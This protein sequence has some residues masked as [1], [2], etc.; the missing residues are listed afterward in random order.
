M[1]KAV[2][3]TT[4]INSFR[5]T[6]FVFKE[7]KGSSLQDLIVDLSIITRDPA[8]QGDIFVVSFPSHQVLFRNTE[9]PFTQLGRIEA[10]IGYEVENLIMSPLEEMVVDFA[11]LDQTPT[12]SSVLVASVKR[13]L[14]RDYVS[15]L[16]QGG[17]VPDTIDVDSL[18][19]ARLVEE[20][21]GKRSIGLLDIGVV[22]GS[23]SIFQDG[24]L[25]FTRSIPIEAPGGSAAE[26]IRPVLDDVI[27]SVKA[28]QNTGDELLEEM[29]LTGGGSR[30][31]GLRSYVEQALGLR[32][33]DL[34]FTT[35]IPSDFPLPEEANVLGAVAMGL[36]LRGLRREKGRVDLVSKMPAHSEV[37]PP[38]IKKKVLKVAG[39]LLL[40][41]VLIGANFFLGIVAKERRY[42]ALKAEVRR[43]FKE[44]F[45]EVRGITNEV[46]QAREMVRRMGEGG[47][48]IRSSV[49]HSN[50]EILREIAQRLPE[51]SKI[52]SL[53]M[54]DVRINLRG[55]ATS[56][57]LVDEVEKVL[58]GS[59]LVEDV[60]VGNVELARRGGQG[61]LFKMVLSRKEK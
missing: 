1:I 11:L 4:S 35:R 44:A 56:F 53:D 24:K 32:V 55:T 46:Q 6:G 18:A 21:G 9:L 50:L 25:R 15:A 19:L 58:A 42:S 39:A 14:V 5:V 2:Q 38:V 49:G 26:A 37:F 43:V 61:V 47:V 40:L 52:V 22:K 20:M 3:L 17:I 12:V 41:L 16:G 28:L 45:P 29:W 59:P 36:A 57:S 48:Q 51:G 30:L 31:R 60:K 33:N 8:L 13:E 7:R 54:D 10:T 34:D 23:V 27:F